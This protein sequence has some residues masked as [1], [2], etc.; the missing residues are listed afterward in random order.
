M[1][2]LAI[3]VGVQNMPK[4]LSLK[5]KLELLKLSIDA[6]SLEVEEVRKYYKYQGSD[7]DS[8]SE[9]MILSYESVKEIDFVLDSLNELIELEND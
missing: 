4:L 5:S 3:L 1:D 9:S 2:S 8:S 6:I 7:A